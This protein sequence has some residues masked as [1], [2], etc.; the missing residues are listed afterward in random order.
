MF[1]SINNI[2]EVLCYSKYLRIKINIYGD[3]KNI[4]CKVD[5]LIFFYL[6]IINAF[7]SSTNFTIDV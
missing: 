2:N 5:G 6:K 1:H 7:F 4:F 3:F